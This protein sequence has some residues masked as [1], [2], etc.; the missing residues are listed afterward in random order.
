MRALEQNERRAGVF[1]SSVTR[2]TSYSKPK[3]NHQH[4]L[5]FSLVVSSTSNACMRH[6]LFGCGGRSGKTNKL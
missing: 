4:F 2:E 3:I 6:G 1:E 5:S